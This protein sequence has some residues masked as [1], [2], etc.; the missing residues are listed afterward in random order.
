M[1]S[2]SIGFSIRATTGSH[3]PAS[4]GGVEQEQEQESKETTFTP[5][6]AFETPTTDVSK[7]DSFYSLE[8]S[9]RKKHRSN[10][11]SQRIA[12]IAGTGPAVS[13][14]DSPT[15]ILARLD[16]CNVPK[17]EFILATPNQVHSL[18]IKYRTTST[19]RTRAISISTS[20]SDTDPSADLLS[21]FFLEESHRRSPARPTASGPNRATT[22]TTTTTTSRVFRPITEHDQE[23][24]LSTVEEAG[25]DETDTG[26]GLRPR[27]RS[28]KLPVRYGTRPWDP[29]FTY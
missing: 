6:L 24:G 11:A 7:L 29:E 27:P 10:V 18:A 14:L 15:S 4:K 9:R 21:G 25:F 20:D 8:S 26:Y 16:L 5:P 2:D 23:E 17:N 19:L 13:N 1:S 28:T 22:T 3:S 12:R